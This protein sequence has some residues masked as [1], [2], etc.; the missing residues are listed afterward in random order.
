MQLHANALP[1]STRKPNGKASD[2][3]AAFEGEG[4]QGERQKR[5]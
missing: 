1:H 5:Q 4:R 3:R 2:Y